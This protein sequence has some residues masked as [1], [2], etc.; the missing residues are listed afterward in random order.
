MCAFLSIWRF[1]P[2]IQIFWIFLNVLKE[3]NTSAEIVKTKRKTDPILASQS[4][5]WWKKFVHSSIST[6]ILNWFCGSY[7]HKLALI[8]RLKS[9]VQR[10]N[11]FFLVI[12]LW[13]KLGSPKNHWYF[14]NLHDLPIGVEVYF[15][16]SGTW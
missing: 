7:K 12:I 16:G 15:R 13:R 11:M 2:H 4:F 8:P 6:N 14:N 1:C 9:T 10:T 5:I 3:L